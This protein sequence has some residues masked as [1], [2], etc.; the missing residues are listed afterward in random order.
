MKGLHI[1][2]DGN[3][4]AYRANCTTELYTKSGQRTSAIIGVLNITHSVMENLEKEYDLPIKEVIYAWDLGHSP[5][6]KEVF[7]EYKSNRNK[8][9]KTEEDKLWMTEFIEQANILYENLPLFGVKCYRK[10]GWEGD[11][12]IYGLSESLTQL[13]PEDTVVIVST[14][15]DFHQ[16]IAEKIHLFSPIKQILYTLDNYEELMGIPQELFLTYKILKGDTSDG[17]PGISGIGEKTGKNLVNTY[18]NLESLLQSK[19]QLIKS[20]R[21]EKIF[22]PEGL[23]IL[24]RNNQLINLKD[25]V[26]L[27]E[28]KEEIQEVINS[29]PYVDTKKS[30]DFL[31]KYQLT[32]ILVKY[33]NW[34][35]I[36]EEASE[37]FY[38]D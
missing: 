25:Y 20:K 35:E 19:E 8:Q 37:N 26:D 36:F 10:K 6:R 24:S 3:N 4:T 15:E 34:I 14:D 16:L 12:L 32:S 17:I 33:K 22:T 13:Y 2:L 18:G 5:R 29:E 27:T 7:P 23:S 28:V 31:M 9:E 21:T 11:D 1:L 38:D 30:K